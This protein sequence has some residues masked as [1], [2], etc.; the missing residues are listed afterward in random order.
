MTGQLPEIEACVFDAYGTLFDVHAAAARCKDDLGD[1]EEALSNLWRL[2]Q[3]QYTWLRSLMG[4]YEDF[5]TLTGDALDFAM[6]SVGLNNADLRK[7]LM[8]LYLQ[9]DA[10]PEVKETLDALKTKGL[11]TAILSNGSPEMLNAAVQNADISEV[12]DA[13]ISVDSIGIY[14]PAPEVYGL[15]EREMGVKRNKVC[16]LSSNGW[17]AQGAAHFGFNVV[18]INRFAQKQERIPGDL[19]GEITTL[20][21]LL[22]L[23]P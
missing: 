19:K 22:P 18:W 4:A 3:L 20:D 11:K 8:E 9:L 12:L 16:F 7:K 1:K 2:K 23:L 5:W 21:Q 6:E 13:Q 17:D 14:K 15:V 10:Y